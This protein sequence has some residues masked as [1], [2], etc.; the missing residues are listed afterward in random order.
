[1]DLYF[2]RRKRHWGGSQCLLSSLTGHTDKRI[3]S[4]QARR[5]Q[6][7]AAARICQLKVWRRRLLQAQFSR[8]AER[9]VRRGRTGG[10]SSRAGHSGGSATGQYATCSAV[11]YRNPHSLSL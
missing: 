7:A 8:Q 4:R 6:P 2:A 9:G 11:L 5:R 1:M 10:T 3:A